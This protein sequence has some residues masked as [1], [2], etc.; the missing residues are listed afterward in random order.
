MDETNY[1]DAPEDND[2]PAHESEGSPEQEQ[3]TP[4]LL[5]REAWPEAKPGETRTFRCVRVMEKEIEVMPEPE[6]EKEPREETEEEPAE[7][8]M[9]D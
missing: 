3:G 5:N 2:A 7:M 4:V 9:M 8:G 1:Y 6:E